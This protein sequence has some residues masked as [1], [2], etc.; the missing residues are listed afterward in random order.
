MSNNHGVHD[1]QKQRNKPSPTDCTECGVGR[2]GLRKQTV[3]K[4]KLCLQFKSKTHIPVKT[5]FLKNPTF[6]RDTD[7]VGITKALFRYLPK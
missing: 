6:L 7:M 5:D 2:N 4:T 1:E 3:F